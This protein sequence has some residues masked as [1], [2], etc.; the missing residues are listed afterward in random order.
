MKRLFTFAGNKTLNFC[1]KSLSLTSMMFVFQA[2]YG[3]PRD[4]GSD[5]L[6]HGTVVNQATGEPIEGIKV[7]IGEN[8][9]HEITDAKGEFYLYLPSNQEH[10]L[11][12]KSPDEKLQFQNK[13]TTII[14][15]RNEEISFTIALNPCF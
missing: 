11:S 10:S 5:A 4:F 9:R 12:F 3:T 13:D 6:L 7:T 8:Y 2:C 15:E 14:P 1:M